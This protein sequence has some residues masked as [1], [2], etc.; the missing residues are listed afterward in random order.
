MHL[1]SISAFS[2][3]H[4]LISHEGHNFLTFTRLYLIATNLMY[5]V[6]IVHTVSHVRINLSSLNQHSMHHL[7]SHTTYH[8]DIVVH[9]KE[10]LKDKRKHA[11]FS[12]VPRY[13]KNSFY[14]LLSVL[15]LKPP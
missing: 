8:S 10:A 15:S 3:D 1:L 5:S 4:F 6:N 14:T 11:H 2:F 9:I 7:S 13:Y 12:R